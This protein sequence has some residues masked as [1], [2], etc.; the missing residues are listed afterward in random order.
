MQL[1]LAF[2]WVGLQLNY[3]GHPQLEFASVQ[4]G[5]GAHVE[6]IILVS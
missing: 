5:W 2:S 6:N 4:I 3:D 1:E